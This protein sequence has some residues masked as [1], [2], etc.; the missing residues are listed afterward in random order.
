[1]QYFGRN[2]EE[3]KSGSSAGEGT[4]VQSAGDGSGAAGTASKGPGSGSESGSKAEG[5]LPPGWVKKERHKPGDAG[6]RVYYLHEPSGKRLVGCRL[7][8]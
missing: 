5:P 8:K 3:S 1:M 6:Y 4:K 2:K 7:L